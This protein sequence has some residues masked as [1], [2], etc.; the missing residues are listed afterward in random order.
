MK[1][2]QAEKKSY[3]DMIQLFEFD[4]NFIEHFNKK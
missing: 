2:F 3:N 4:K 1:V